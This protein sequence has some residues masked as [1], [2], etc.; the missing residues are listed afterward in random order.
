MKGAVIVGTGSYVPERILANTDLEKMVDTS[1]EWITTRTGIQTRRIAGPGE[2][3]AQMAAI[4]GRRA[5]DMAGVVPADLDLIIVGTITPDKTMPSCGCL[6]QKEIGA[7][8]A[9]AY[10]VNAACSGFIYGLDIADKYLKADPSMKILVIGSETLSSRTNWQ[11]RNTC[12]LFGDGAGACVVTGDTSESGMIDSRL[13]SDGRLWKLLYLE[14]RPRRICPVVPPALLENGSEENGEGSAIH[15]EGRD[16]FKYA[17][18]AME[19]AVID[20]LNR[21]GLGIDDISLMIPHQANIRILKSLAERL[22]IPL[23]KVYVIVQKYGNTSAAS[24]PIAIDEANREGR[25]QRGDYIL[26]CVFGGGFTW[27][28]ALMKW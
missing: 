20:L 24:V 2:G 5:L 15:M 26:F 16:V 6:V 1:N 13:Y 27:G 17:V 22:A 4:A 28:T 7:V 14:N 21:T 25:L 8:N 12:V 9:A 11:D 3:T 23:E 10:D 19:Q 18:R